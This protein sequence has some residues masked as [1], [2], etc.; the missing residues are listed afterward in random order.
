M[1]AHAEPI[2]RE[3]G[4]PGIAACNLAEGVGVPLPGQSLLMAG[5]L[6]ALRGE[7]AIGTV[8]VVALVASVLGNCAGYWIG[9]RGG[10][11]LLRRARISEERLL[12]VE[13]FFGRH[14]VAVVLVARFVDGLRQAAPVVA[15]SMKMPWWRFLAASVVG[16]AAWVA[17]WGAGAY[18]LGRDFHAVLARVHALGHLGWWLAGAL[19]LAMVAWLF[20]RRGGARDREPT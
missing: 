14:G 6:L 4:Y 13:G 3:Y 2:L 18:W 20:L 8:L 5:S 1:M 16:C 11:A 7:F 12:R 9:R 10:R 19:I 17:V 15:G